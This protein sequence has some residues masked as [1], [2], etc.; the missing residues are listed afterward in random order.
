MGEQ[1]AL[2][3]LAGG[4]QAAPRYRIATLRTTAGERFTATCTGPGGSVGGY[5]AEEAAHPGEGRGRRAYLAR[6]DALQPLPVPDG[7]VPVRIGD[8]DAV[9]CKCQGGAY[10]ARHRHTHRL[11][12]IDAASLTALGEV[13]GTSEDHR[14]VVVWIKGR[15]VD[16]AHPGDDFAV[17]DANDDLVSVGYRRVRSGL[18]QGHHPFLWHRGQEVD[19]GTLGGRFG[20]AVAVNAEG[21]VAGHAHD[22]HGREVACLWWGGGRLNL[23]TLGGERSQASHLNDAGEVVGWSYTEGGRPHAFLYRHAELHDLNDLAILD[24]GLTLTAAVRIAPDGR[25]LAEARREGQGRVEWVLLT[26]VPTH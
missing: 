6:G 13:V 20:M 16:L 8:G 1:A 23:G 17:L 2:H 18:G 7:A 22:P 5:V 21:L 25:I 3:F 11:S 14:D 12:G 4:E 26:P 24:E 19:L 9:L 10:L 15:L